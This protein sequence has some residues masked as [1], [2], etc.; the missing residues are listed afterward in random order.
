MAKVDFPALWPP[1]KHVLS[2]DQIRERAVEPYPDCARRA[3]L[4]EKLDAWVTELRAIGIVGTVW[5]DGSF[6]TEKAEPGD[7]D[8]VLW[9][10]GWGDPALDTLENRNRAEQLLERGAARAVFDLDLFVVDPSPDEL[11]HEEAYWRGLWGFCHD[12][13]TAKGFVEIEL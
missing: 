11:M 1:G 9:S 3:E 4:Y 12:R 10:P 7:I 5:V 8:C 6:A 13:A 2:L